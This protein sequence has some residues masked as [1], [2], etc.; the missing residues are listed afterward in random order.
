MGVK[1]QKGCGK[2]GGGGA[3]GAAR[4]EGGGGVGGKHR[5]PVNKIE[6]KSECSLDRR[7]TRFELRK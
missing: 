7:V 3:G 1:T 5:L 4:G 2:R 6:E